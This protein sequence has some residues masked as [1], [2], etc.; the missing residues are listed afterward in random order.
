MATKNKAENVTFG[1]PKVGGAIFTAPLGTQIPTDASSE[2]D[3]AF[4]NL[5]YISEDGVANSMDME[6]NKI[7]AWGGDTVATSNNGRSDTFTYTL[8]EALNV[9]VLKEVYGEENVI[10]D[11]ETGL[12]IKSNS[13]PMNPHIIVIE[14]IWNGGI[15]SRIVIPIGQVSSVEEVTYK[16]NEVVGYGITLEALPD[17][18]GNTHYDYKVKKADATA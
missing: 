9:S 18:E 5:G 4:K 16:D 14:Q 8:I 12:T 11:L 2:L 13:N 3:Q 17:G 10:G 6:V 7:K 1:K 15:L